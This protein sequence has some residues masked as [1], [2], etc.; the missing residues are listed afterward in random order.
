MIFFDNENCKLFFIRFYLLFL[1]STIGF[2][3]TIIGM[4]QA[5]FIVQSSPVGENTAELEQP[6]QHSLGQSYGRP[7]KQFEQQLQ[8][9]NPKEVLVKPSAPY[10]PYPN[11][12]EPSIP[13]PPRTPRRALDNQEYLYLNHIY[14]QPL[15]IAIGDF[16]SFGWLTLVG[17]NKALR[18]GLDVYNAG[19]KIAFDGGF[20][21]YVTNGNLFTESNFIYPVEPIALKFS[22][23]FGFDVSFFF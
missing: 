9:T 17:A 7:A 8:Q 4:G 10:P 6:R 16:V 21:E 23:R 19:N 18:L 1:Y 14:F 11:Y 20:F 15:T 2:C 12:P 3:I 22:L 13:C 5:Y